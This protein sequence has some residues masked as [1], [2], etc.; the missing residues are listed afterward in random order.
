[1]SENPAHSNEKNK[2]RKS[3][4]T[5]RFRPGQTRGDVIS[6]EVGDQ[7]RGVVIGKNIIQ[8]GTIVVPVWLLL[9]L[10][11]GAA[12][13]LVF[14]FVN[15]RGPTEMSGEF[16]IAV[17]EFGQLGADGRIKSVP[18]GRSLSGW[19]F[20]RL[21]KEYETF[22]SELSVQIW[23]DSLDLGVKLGPIAGATPEERYAA[24][25]E[26]AG[27]IKAHIIVYGYFIDEGNDTYFAPEFYV[28]GL[29]DAPELV[30]P[31]RLGSPI[32][33]R[34]P[35]ETL[36]QTLQVNPTLNARVKALTLFTIG[37]AWELAGDPAKALQ[38]FQLAETDE[39]WPDGEGREILYLFQGRELF[40]LW[41]AGEA[42]EADV[43]AAFKK[44][45]AFNQNYGRAYIGI[46]NF[47]REKSDRQYE[48]LVTL[49]AANEM[50]TAVFAQSLAQFEN[51]ARLATD[52]YL[53]ALDTASAFPEGQVALK[54]RLGLGGIQ[55]RQGALYMVIKQFE[56]AGGFF[57]KA[58]AEYEKALALAET[59][60][61]RYRAL[62]YL[63][64]GIAYHQKAFLRSQQADLADSDS[65][66]RQWLVSAIAA[67]GQCIA[68]VD[69]EQPDWF[70]Q[71]LKTE[72]CSPYIEAAQADLNALAGGVE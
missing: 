60:D 48:S 53:Q 61:H 42:D 20:E 41:Q 47:H 67:Y 34:L 11:A 51:D 54:S 52:A 49:V 26:L 5:D 28:T 16:N 38:Q 33:V 4:K 66:V 44:A 10:L 35:I 32:A 36:A 65:L 25:R 8:I 43:S 68:H 1:M 59:D 40:F 37:F 55:N 69:A 24:A 3:I 63:G 31:Y 23:H 7:A 14:Q 15:S 19:L 6:G 9:A 13:I 21:Q 58:L 56:R 46:G 50:E 2:R 29:P 22:P 57:D 70:L 45:L 39:A 27:R 71:Q 64:V 62:A 12:A 18:D 17:A 30:G 72:N